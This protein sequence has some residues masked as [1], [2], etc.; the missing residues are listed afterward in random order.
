MAGSIRWQK[1]GELQAR[2]D[3][4]T[5]WTRSFSVFKNPVVG[6]LIRI[7]AQNTVLFDAGDGFTQFLTA[8]VTKISLEE[9]WFEAV[10][11]IFH[12]YSQ[13]F[14]NRTSF[15]GITHLMRMSSAFANGMTI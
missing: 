13:V 6:Q 8:N 3:I 4:V 7:T 15:S 9:D 5:Y 12:N 2:F 14:A 11:I 1:V 10:S